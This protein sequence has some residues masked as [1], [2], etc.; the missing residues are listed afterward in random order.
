M[1][2][3][4]IRPYVPGGPAGG[5]TQRAGLNG[6]ARQ[7]VGEF[8]RAAN[9]AVGEV[10]SFLDQVHMTNPP[11]GVPKNTDEAGQKPA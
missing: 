5:R 8:S 10:A 1:S 4:R 11:K 3:N 9:G 7:A 2:I 6:E